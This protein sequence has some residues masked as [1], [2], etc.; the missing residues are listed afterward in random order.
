MET[1]VI[2]REIRGN[3]SEICG[4]TAVMGMTIVGVTAEIVADTPIMHSYQCCRGHAID[5]RYLL[6]CCRLF[7]WVLAGEVGD[8]TDICGMVEDGGNALGDGWNG[9]KCLSHAA[10]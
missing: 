7:G 4:N 2:P 9:N 10:L 6:G 3:R 5:C 1:I 8:G